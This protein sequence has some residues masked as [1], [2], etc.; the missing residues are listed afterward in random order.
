MSESQNGMLQLDGRTIDAV[1][2][3]TREDLDK[4]KLEAKKEHKD[5]RNLFLA[6]EGCKLFFSFWDRS[7]LTSF[8]YLILFSKQTFDLELVL[9]KVSLRV[10][11]ARDNR[12]SYGKNKCS[13]I[14]TCTFRESVFVFTIFH[15]E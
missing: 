1:L 9:H 14:F 7:L 11:W 10:T 13:E 4:Q 6:R 2:A 12:M 8:N 5:K 15:L 3:V